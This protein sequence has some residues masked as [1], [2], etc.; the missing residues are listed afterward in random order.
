MHTQELAAERC[1]LTALPDHEMAGSAI[2]ALARSPRVERFLVASLRWSMGYARTH[3]EL[4]PAAY[5]PAPRETAPERPMSDVLVT[6]ELQALAAASGAPI[7]PENAWQDIVR[8]WEGE[9]VPALQHIERETDSLLREHG[10]KIHRIDVFDR[11]HRRMHTAP[12]RG[13]PTVTIPRYVPPTPCRYG[14]IGKHAG[15]SIGID[16]QTELRTTLTTRDGGTARAGWVG[17][18]RVTFALE[19]RKRGAGWQGKRAAKSAA[20][21]ASGATGKRGPSVTPWG[22]S[23]RSLPAAIKRDPVAAE[24]AERIEQV[25]RTCAPGVP[26]LLATGETVTVVDIGTSTVEHRGTVYPIREWSRRAALAADAID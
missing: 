16:G 12:D 14:A 6:Q 10:V 3:R 8:S 17:H 2:R 19:G 9:Y 23:P 13:V 7:S 4:Y 24:V 21:A 26:L 25:L 18:R 11:K 15:E 1:R 22:M 5:A 20:R